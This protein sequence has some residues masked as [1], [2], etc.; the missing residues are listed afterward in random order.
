M[1]AGFVGGDD[2]AL[3]AM[4]RRAPMGRLGEPPEIAEAVLWL[5]SDAASFVTGAVVDPDGGVSAI[6]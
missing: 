6:G 2:E 5:L 1:L 3:E 4:G